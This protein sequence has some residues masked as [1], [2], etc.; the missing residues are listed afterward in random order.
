MLMFGL[1]ACLAK[2]MDIPVVTITESVEQKINWKEAG[3]EASQ[4]LS[5]YIQVDTTNPNGNETRGAEF[6]GTFLEKEGIPYEI[7]ESSE[8]RGNLIARIRGDG[9]EKPICLLSHIDV[10]TAEPEKWEKDPL[11]GEISDGY[12]WGRGALDMKSMGVMELLTMVWLKR[13]DIPLKRDVIL[14][15]VADEEV[16][17]EGARFIRDNYWDFIQCSHMIN[18]GGLGLQDMMFEG[19][20]V[21]PISVGEKGAVWLKMIASGEPGHGST[22]RPNEA[23]RYLMEALDALGTRELGEEFSPQLVS[24]MNAVGQ[25][26]GGATG[27]VLRNKTLR[28]VLVTPKLMSNPLTRAAMI[29][30]VHVT[31]FGGQNKPNVVPSEVYAILDCRIQPG[32]DPQD[33]IASLEAI[34]ASEQIHFEIISA[35][36]GSVSPTEDPLYKALAYQ[37]TKGES[38]AVAGPVISVGYTDSN[39]FRPLGVKAYGFHPVLLTEKDMEGFHGHNEK[40]STSNMENGL[41]KLF[42][43]VYAVSVQENALK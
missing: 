36:S 18:E 20:N 23:P 43:S 25:H 6:L 15:A 30:T 3:E 14:L 38:D 40:I 41:R 7:H 19:Q 21:Y 11:S 34:V 1:L 32:V 10:V 17:G 26:K 28:N 13:L 2:P 37:A 22:P 4:L 31:G 8:N 16:Q 5:A 27:I 29:N 33:F 24:L 35:T 12:I 9:T 42:L 39:Y